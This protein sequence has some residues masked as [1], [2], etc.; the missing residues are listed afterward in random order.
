MAAAST[1]AFAQAES[2]PG[3]GK[4]MG[5]ELKKRFA[6]A[7]TN[8]DGLLS[9]EEAKAGMPFVHRN[10][11]AIDTAKTGQVSMAEIATFFRT[12]GAAGKAAN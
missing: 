4:Q 3:R 10:F 11:D 9:R 12:K 6:T 2:D 8:H 5:A 7:D 1:A